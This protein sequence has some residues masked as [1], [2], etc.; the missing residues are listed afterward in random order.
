MSGF[1]HTPVLEAEV[2]AYL[3]PEPGKRYC[4]GTLG[5]SGHARRIL[6]RSA[7]D[8]QLVGIDRDSNALAVARER[9]AEFGS[10]AIL[11]HGTFGR[12]DEIL[13]DLAEH[14]PVYA[15]E[16]SHDASAGRMIES[17]AA[18][19]AETSPETSPETSVAPSPGTSPEP[20]GTPMT[21]ALVDGFLLDL[22]PSSPQFD[23]PERGFSFQREGPIDMRM[24]QSTGEPALQLMRRLNEKELARVLLELGEERYAHRIAAR[25]KE[26]LRQDRLH[27]T[28][29]LATLVD[30]AIPAPV[31]RR[32]K[33]HPATRT[34]QALRMA[35]NGELQQLARFLE[36]FPSLLAPG[37]RCVI[38]SFHS[39]EDRLVKR[40]FRDLAWTSSLP[41]DLARQA[42][43][44]VDPICL[45][46]TRKAVF[47]GEDEVARNPRARSA[48]LRAC[49]KVAA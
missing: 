18:P 35:V 20:F 42:G 9:L 43:E 33:I 45:P 13:R 49:Q 24:D 10:R 27:T 22:G 34:F 29:E 1:V 17:A 40:A 7:P 12:V 32:M 15:T 44:R 48:R 47:A 6:E 31:K 41:P 25:I 46:L 4:D 38:I 30:D 14:G 5:G 8:G 26:A 23:H 39:L 11:V 36:V 21:S 37:G 28:T 3:A 19:S 16:R 2:L